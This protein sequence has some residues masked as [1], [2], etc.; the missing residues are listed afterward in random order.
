MVSVNKSLMAQIQGQALAEQAR[1]FTYCLVDQTDP[2]CGGTTVAVKLG[3][4]FFLATAGHVINNDHC[5][6]VLIRDSVAEAVSDFVTRHWDEQLDVGLL[7]VNSSDS[8][9]FD[10]ARQDRLLGTIDQE[11][12]LPTLVVGFPGQFNQPILQTQLTHKSQIKVCQRDALTYHTVVLPRSEWPSEDIGEPLIEGRDLLIDFH[13]ETE[14]KRLTP[15]ASGT[16]APA[17][18]SPPL[19][20]HGLSGGGILRLPVSYVIPEF[21]VDDVLFRFFYGFDCCDSYRISPSLYTLLQP[22]HLHCP[23]H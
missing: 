1:R 4:H 8:Y 12:V 14:L 19:D 22:S 11:Q 3:E 17:V 7:E 10:F 5:L 23:F 18:N 21:I 9:L 16:E 2:T 6:K 20:P 13:P 15:Q